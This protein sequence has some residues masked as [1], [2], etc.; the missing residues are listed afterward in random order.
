MPM[1]TTVS[2]ADYLAGERMAST[3]SEWLDGYVE[4]MAGVTMQHALIAANIVGE[5]RARL[6]DSA[7]SV[8]GSDLRIKAGSG[9]YTYPDATVI[10]E[11][12]RFDDA[13]R[14]T[15]VNPTALFEVLSSSTEA[16]DR[17]E[18]F[19]RYR[20]IASLQ[21]YAMVSQDLARIECYHRTGD[22]WVLVEH[23]GL[24]ASASLPAMGCELPLHEVYARVD[25]PRSASA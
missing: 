17:G 5:L 14:D 16:F 24:E 15:V 21:T 8:F 11:A 6:R 22:A 25:L 7:C 20:R 18:K 4:A 3:K 23:D 12:A 19:H 1:L 2:A 13:V 10:C 9:L